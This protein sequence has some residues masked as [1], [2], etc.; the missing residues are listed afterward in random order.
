[1]HSDYICCLSKNLYQGSWHATKKE[2]LQENGINTILH[3]GFELTPS[4]KSD[5]C[6]YQHLALDDNSQSTDY[7]FDKLL[8]PLISWLAEETIKKN[9]K[10]LICCSAGRSRSVAI[11]MAY[12]ILQ[13]SITYDDCLALVQGKRPIANPNPSFTKRLQL[14]HK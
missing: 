10:V 4:E 5:S 9:N 3:V 2:I 11:C 8:P 1:M 7:L 13:Y 12:L 14:L 6:T